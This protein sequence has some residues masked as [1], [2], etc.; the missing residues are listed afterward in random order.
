MSVLEGDVGE[1]KIKSII[2]FD[3]SYDIIIYRKKKLLSFLRYGYWWITNA[4]GWNSCSL[5][6]RG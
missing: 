1:L 2:G 6:D 3:G 5:S 4:P